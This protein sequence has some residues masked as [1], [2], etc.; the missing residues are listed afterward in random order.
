MNKSFN[1]SL[2]GEKVVS[3]LDVFGTISVSGTKK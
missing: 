1:H 3:V 2:F